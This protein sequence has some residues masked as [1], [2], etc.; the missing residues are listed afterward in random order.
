M[1]E[2]HADASESKQPEVPRSNLRGIGR[3]CYST[4]RACYR[5][6]VEIGPIA[7]LLAIILTNYHSCRNY[8]LTKE[9]NRALLYARDVL[10]YPQDPKRFGLVIVNAGP[11]PAHIV[12]HKSFLGTVAEDKPIPDIESLDSPIVP[13]D[14][15]ID[16]ALPTTIDFYTGEY[17]KPVADQDQLYSI[18][19]ENRLRMFILGK[20]QYF[21]GHDEYWLR[22]CKVLSSRAGWQTCPI[23]AKP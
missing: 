2:S 8:E 11:K 19:T 6:L 4:G 16:K 13:M 12:K 3:L 14:E 15:I 17:C 20:L 18:L 21:D 7:T 1:S 23:S 22:Y 10:R 9:S 5:V